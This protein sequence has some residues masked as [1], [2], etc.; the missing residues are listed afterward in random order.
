MAVTFA[1][2]MSALEGSVRRPLIEAFV[3]WA[4]AEDSTRLNT[5]A[6][7]KLQK[8]ALVLHWITDRHPHHFD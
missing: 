2:T 1:F 7:A 3:D 6:N 5:K 4:R 8:T